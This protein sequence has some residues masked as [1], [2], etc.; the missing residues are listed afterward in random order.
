MPPPAPREFRAAWI[1]TVANIDWPSRKNLTVAQQ[2]AE[3]I[4]IVE[5]AK[6]LNLNALILQVR[7][8]A[9]A[10]YASPFEPWS[11]YLTGEQGKAPQPYYDPLQMWIEQA[12]QRGLE[13]HAWFNPYRVR[14]SKAQS[15]LSPKH[16]ASTRPGLVKTYGDLLWLDPGEPEAA[17][18]TVKVILD[19]VRRYDIDAVHIDDYFYPYPINHTAGEI[20]FPDENSWQAYLTEGGALNRADWRRQNVNRLVEQ[21]YTG[22]RSEKNWVKFGISP[23]GIGRPDRRPPGIEGFSQ[24]DKLYADVELWLEKAWLDYLSP[25]LYW[26]IEQSAQSFPVLLN[27]WRQANRQERH[28]WPGLFTS[29]I[30]NSEK[31]W[32]AEEIVRQ[33]SL[34]RETLSGGHIHFS[35]I[36]LLEN[37]QK[38]GDALQSAS[39]SSA[40]L[41]PT[42]PWLAH[43]P[44]P[45]PQFLV[46]ATR[47][48]FIK[49]RFIAQHG[50]RNIALWA[51]YGNQWRFYV[52]PATQAETNLELTREDGS[53]NLVWASTV[54]RLG[55]QSPLVAIPL[56][57]AK[58]AHD[59][60]TNL[61]RV[62][63]WGGTPADAVLA[64]LHTI[65][66]I[67]LHHQGQTFPIERDPAEYLR[68]LQAW[69]RG[70]RRWLDIPYHYVIDMQ[71]QIYEARSIDYA[72][73][74]NTDYDPTGHALIEVVGN[75]DEV[76]PNAVQLHAIVKLMTWLIIQYNL[77][78]D[79]IAGHKD[80]SN[81]TSCPGKN[82]YRYLEN[83][84]FHEQVKNNL[85]TIHAQ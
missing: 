85:K 44:P 14:H 40:A 74:T 80:Y 22:I 34:T 52:L 82:L 84:W 53:L 76:E 33:V 39:Y 78:P 17:Q 58:L 12:H 41:V 24:Y 43:E 38:I 5:R 16:I 72:G 9:D 77:S 61:I 37:R 75:L 29:R 81:K 56:E 1:A 25:Q 45:A 18:H 83:G 73:D 66:R 11:E 65:T 19:V 26:P 23:F 7:P 15:P 71:G 3:I 48:G 30:D 21:L 32:P 35:M 28:L 20:D 59:M 2:Q 79:T 47:P 62:A 31:S 51:R 67:T 54:D 57:K 27:Y 8:S 69:S 42:T 46:S 68:S 6:E 49:I 64:K 70:V 36:A 55:N 10:L 60:Q 63:Q 50:V 4:R 13:L